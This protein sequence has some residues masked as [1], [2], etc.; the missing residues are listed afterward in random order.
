[1]ADR[2]H[3]AGLSPHALRTLPLHGGHIDQFTVQARNILHPYT[4]RFSDL[5]KIAKC[6]PGS[7][8]CAHTSAGWLH[9]SCPLD[10][11]CIRLKRGVLSVSNRRPTR[12]DARIQQE[13]DANSALLP[14]L[15]PPCSL[16]AITPPRSNA[17]MADPARSWTGGQ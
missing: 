12:A 5:L 10:K 3:L 7:S 8:A 2:A 13:F 6:Q 11:P 4:P 14:C 17:M 1:M 16:R 9:P 15:L